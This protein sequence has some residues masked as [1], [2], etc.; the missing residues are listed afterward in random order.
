MKIELSRSC[1]A[2]FARRAFQPRRAFTLIE[3]LVVIAIIAILAALL[4]PALSQAKR[5]AQGIA[6]MNNTKQLT[7]AYLM[8]AMDNEDLALVSHDA[9]GQKAPIWCAGSVA[10]V[11]E[12]I[13]EDI[14]RTSPSF[15]Y[16]KS[17]KV[18][19]C[20]TDLAGLRYQG[21]I[22]L[23]NRSYGLNGF[24]GVPWNHVPPNNDI[25]KSA[26]KMGDITAPGPAAVYIFADEHEN[27]IN[28]THFLP[29]ADYHSFG[30]QDWLDCPSGRHGNATGFSF[31]D[32]HSEIHK[33]T[34]SDVT[35]IEMSGGLV[36]PNSFHDVVPRPGP[37]TFE[38]CKTH[39]AANR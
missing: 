24:M 3:L 30:N 37:K 13:S 18:F 6:C 14:I 11:P 39:V 28:D 19:H 33:W 23:R 15:S 5:K 7:T 36:V 32:G 2:F 16:L 22:V 9:P 21:Q 31:A 25:L 20:P 34:D 26:I 12:A 4:L 8:Y 1:E 10:T 29:F 27:S 35:K 17:V 38:W